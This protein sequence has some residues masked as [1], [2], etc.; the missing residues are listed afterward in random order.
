MGGKKYNIED[1][2]KEKKIKKEEVEKLYIDLEYSILDLVKKFDVNYRKIEKIL[3][4]FNIKKRNI[5]EACSTNTR[6][7]KY[8]NT[9]IKK[10]GEGI[11]NVSQLETVKEKKAKT[12]QENWG[13]DNIFKIDWFPE[14]VE[15]I[16]IEKF[17]KKRITNAEKISKT[18]SNFSAEKKAEISKK[19]N[20][21]KKENFKNSSDE[22]KDFWHEYRSFV[23]KEIFSKD[24]IRETLSKKQKELWSSLSEEEKYEKMKHL[25]TI[26][27]SSL[28]SRVEKTFI[29]NNIKFEPQYN[30]EN[31]FFDFLIF[32]NVLLEVN[33]DYWHANPEKYLKEDEIKFPG[34]KFIKAENIWLKDKIKKETG[35]N[36]GYR[37]IYLWES[38]IKKM[39]D[40]ELLKFIRKEVEYENK[41]NKKD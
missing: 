6:K 37:V 41:E 10:Y 38:E 3:E 2:I 18:K 34:N 23:S 12:F 31:Y 15:L 20:E 8:K 17:G 7:N 40:E 36:N 4:H 11:T 30:V 14:Y 19:V 16:M 35:L 24:Y 26:S 28:E 29:E 33:G 39:T 1:I 27:K 9:L 25:L 22:W 21:T 32:K 13:E 5:K